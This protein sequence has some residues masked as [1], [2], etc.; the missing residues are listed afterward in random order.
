MQ[1]EMEM[2]GGHPLRRTT[3]RQS[4]P[5]TP[6]SGSGRTNGAATLSTAAGAGAGA[7]STALTASSAGH[8]A[9]GTPPGGARSAR[10]RNNRVSA[11]SSVV[12]CSAM[13]HRE[14]TPTSPGVEG[15]GG[16]ATATE[17]F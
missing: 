15:A 16:P 5:P 11:Q 14:R 10:W 2:T 4:T 17:R 7:A 6:G 3:S 12:L 9:A 13:V 8:G 1:S